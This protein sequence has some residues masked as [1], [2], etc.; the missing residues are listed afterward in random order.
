M[1]NQED[2]KAWVH[3][4]YLRLKHRV[5]QENH[6]AMERYKEGLAEQKLQAKLLRVSKLSYDNQML[7]RE[8]T[9]YKKL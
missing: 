8:L 1:S 9:K 6:A 7:Y 5:S 3:E 4:D 2:Y